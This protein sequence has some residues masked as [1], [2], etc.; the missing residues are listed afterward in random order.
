MPNPTV[1]LKRVRR[2]K[3][4]PRVLSHGEVA[5]IWEA[6]L[7]DRDRTMVGLV[8]DT[9]VR[10]GEI[11]GMTKS[12]LGTFGL[13]VEGKTGAREVPISPQLREML[14]RLGGTSHF[15]LASDGRRLTYWGVKS[16]F[17][18]VFRRAGLEGRKL[19]P[20]TLRHTLATEYCRGGGNVRALQSIMGHERLGT[21]MIY[22]N[23]AGLAVAQDHAQY[24][25]FKTLV[26]ADPAEVID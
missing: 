11:A 18:R 22:V 7:N 4:L 16:A 10:L 14:L 8:L 5:A 12:E 2:R 25:P 13:R 19:G 26:V 15:W 20:H 9:G 24:S 17:R 3:T 21:T 23:P 1:D 6:C